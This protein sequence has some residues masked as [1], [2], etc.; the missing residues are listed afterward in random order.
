MHLIVSLPLDKPE[1]KDIILC[2]VRQGLGSLGK[3]CDMLV[4]PAL[5][6]GTIDSL[7]EAEESAKRVDA[8]V[9]D[10]IKKFM[11]E[12]K[13]IEG[14]ALEEREIFGKAFD[15]YVKTFQWDNVSYN[16]R[17]RIGE[18]IQA[19]EEE[20]KGVLAYYAEKIKTYGEQKKASSHIERKKHGSIYE[21]DIN[22]IVYAH[23]GGAQ[24]DPMQTKLIKKYYLVVPEG[25][26]AAVEDKLSETDGLFMETRHS[27]YASSDGEIIGVLGKAA[28]AEDLDA[29]F[30]REG[31][32]AKMPLGTREEHEE[33]EE[34]DRK[35]LE[36]YED[37]R[38]S[39][40]SFIKMHLPLMFKALLHIKILS[41][42][43]ESIL[44]FGPPSTFCFFV[45]TICKE[46]EKALQ[47]WKRIAKHWRYSG[48]VV[49]VGKVFRS[50]GENQDMHDFVYSFVP[51]FA[52]DGAAGEG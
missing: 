35:V 20:V 2:N 49:N 52:M 47:R 34:K 24:D 30:A 33:L 42:H 18:I 43:I 41:L 32:V 25:T 1:R 21:V 51:G 50:E 13:A 9:Q 37:C 4:V 5:E 28:L 19:M 45:T 44:R 3:S 7:F 10:T 11:A 40:L 12:A 8:L 14:R 27:L 46:R 23:S 17:D 16:Q 48:R 26:K 31:I 15:H 36:K 29:H 6:N 22:G 39:I 38:L